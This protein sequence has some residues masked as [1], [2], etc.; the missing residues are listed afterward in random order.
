M[1]R[2]TLVLADYPIGYPSGFGETLL[3]LFQGFPDEL[4][5]NAYPRHLTP[6][7][8]NSR[9]HAIIFE[10]PQ[11]PRWLP[12]QLG[13]AYFPILKLRQFAAQRAIL[14]QL[15]LIVQKEEIQALLCVPVSP[16]ILS[17]VA[18]LKKSCPALKLVMF[19]MDDWR[20]HHEAHA[21]PY[22]AYR[23]NLL[24]KTL[25]LAANRF[26]ISREMANLYVKE[27]GGDWQVAHN[28][29]Y[30]G[31]EMQPLEFRRKPKTV[32]LGGDVNVF[33]ADAV[34]AFAQAL[35]HY[36]SKALGKEKLSLKIF[37]HVSEECL[38]ALENL[39]A[40]KLF[41]RQS[42]EACL[43]AMRDADLL[44]LPLAFNASISRIARY[45]L[46]TKLAEYL[47][48]GR[49]VLFHAP[50]QSA[51]YNLAKRFGLE[52]RLTS[53]NPTEIESFVTTWAEGGLNITGWQTRA[54]NAIKAEF[55]P[56]IVISRFQAAFA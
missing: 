16:W 17:V 48:I 23:H 3:N 56:T 2:R 25:A 52:P 27:F 43:A 41:G 18:D 31:T 14:K 32:F 40:V 50:R 54:E 44:Y 51:A 26:A 49:P 34:I 15:N 21:L 30:C 36:N 46:P 39:S 33:R 11:R 19:V 53:V 13:K 47:S 10:S 29:R 20:G 45:S 42:H 22:T 4:L 6:S 8:G 55:D 9:G 12:V 28:I 38:G 5:W 1:T 37:G 24:K 7:L 35:E